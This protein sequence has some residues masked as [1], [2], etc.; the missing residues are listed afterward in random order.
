[1]LSGKHISLFLKLKQKVIERDA[2]I[3][4]TFTTGSERLDRQRSVGVFDSG[5]GGLS[6]LE[7]LH[8]QLPAEN[9]IYVA[10]SAWMPYGAL[11][12]EVVRERCRLVSRFLIGQ[13]AKALVVACN[14]ATAAAIES[15]RSEFPLPIIGMEPAVK[16][17]VEATR[18]GV[19]GVLATA[20]T[21][22]SEKFLRLV[23]RFDSHAEVV[24]QPGNGLVELVEAGELTGERTRTL[25]ESHLKPLLSRGIDVLVLGCTHYPF[26]VPLIRDIVGENVVILDTGRAI[27]AEL[28]RQ[29][30]RHDLCASAGETGSV[31]FYSSRANEENRSMISRLWGDEIVL[32]KLPEESDG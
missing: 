26:L 32:E 27:A 5:V 13:G 11:Q 6:V 25:L 30:D 23:K 1:L 7:H 8:R 22:S 28:G 31:R 2:R 9:L 20:G 14:T 10:D 21:L 19:I 15:L 29:L 24:F 12:H 18:N 16:P 17:A 3:I 4:P